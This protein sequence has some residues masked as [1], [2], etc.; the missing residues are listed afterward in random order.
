M[1]ATYL[2]LLQSVAE[3]LLHISGQILAE[4]ALQFHCRLHGEE[5]ADDIKA[6]QMWLLDQVNG[7]EASSELVSSEEPEGEPGDVLLSA[8]LINA[9]ASLKPKKQMYRNGR[10]S[11]AIS[12][13]TM[14]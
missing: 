3:R 8:E 5:S 14:H 10:T 9:L 13:A 11:T 12:Q 7:A 4:N 6:S 2:C 1:K